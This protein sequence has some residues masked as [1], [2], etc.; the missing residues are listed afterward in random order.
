MLLMNVTILFF[1]NSLFDSPDGD[2]CD[3]ISVVDNA[4]AGSMTDLSIVSRP[5]SSLSRVAPENWQTITGKFLGKCTVD[6]TS[7]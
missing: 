7:L 5:P 4:L 3:D 2:M 6:N 1:I